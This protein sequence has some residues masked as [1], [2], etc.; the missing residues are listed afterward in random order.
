MLLLIHSPA[1][2]EWLVLCSLSC[3]S[4]CQGVAFPYEFMEIYLERMECNKC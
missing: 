3:S 2:T 1:L 4:T